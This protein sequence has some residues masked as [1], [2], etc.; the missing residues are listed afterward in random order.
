MAA[1]VVSPLQIYYRKNNV[2]LIWLQPRTF[3]SSSH[4]WTHCIKDER[5]K[6]KTYEKHTIFFRLLIHKPISIQ[7]IIV[8]LAITMKSA[9]IRI[10]H[11][12]II[13]YTRNTNRKIIYFH[14]LTCAFCRRVNTTF[15]LIKRKS[16][17]DV[18][19]IFRINF[20]LNV[21]CESA[22]S[23]NCS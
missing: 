15:V 6:V 7:E 4:R 1:A 21:M 12:N 14:V 10:L 9:W 2:R 18:L 5:K 19:C 13:N 20:S 11:T 8:Q 22:Y 17:S 3:P 16:C 23:M